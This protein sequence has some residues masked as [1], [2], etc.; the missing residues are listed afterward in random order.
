MLIPSSITGFRDIIELKIPSMKVLNYDQG[1]GHYYLSSDASRAIGQVSRYLD[2]FSEDAV[3]GLRDN[4]EIVSYHPRAIIVMG[5]S[6]DWSDEESKSLHGINTRLNNIS[7][8]TYGHLL[9]MGKR[10]LENL[11]WTKED[12]S[13]HSG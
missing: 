8:I 7:I 10:V 6:K 1:H 9:M 12:D 2:V 4:P 13:L 5:R 11:N 3:K